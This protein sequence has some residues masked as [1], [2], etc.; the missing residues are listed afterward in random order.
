MEFPFF[1]GRLLLAGVFVAAGVSKLADRNGWRQ[2]LTEFGVPASLAAPLGVSLPVL[3]I[4]V[5]IILIPTATSWWG[6]LGALV[7]LLLF[8]AGIGANL[9]QGRKPVC[10]CFGRLDSAPI[11]W[12]TLVR[13]GGLAAIAALV[14]SQDWITPHLPGADPWLVIV[15]TFAGAVIL[16]QGWLL[17]RLY[18]RL[19]ALETRLADTGA[20]PSRKG[21]PIGAR[22]P[23][24]KLAALEGDTITLE[25]LRS[26]GKTI[27]LVFT[28]P[29]CGPC[30]KLLPTL[31]RWQRE[32]VS[33]LT[34]ANISQGSPEANR[35]NA[36]KYGLRNVLTQK[37]VE[38]QQAYRITATPGAVLVRVDGTIGS[39]MAVGEEQIGA[40]IQKTINVPRNVQ[41]FERALRAVRGRLAL[42]WSR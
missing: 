34:I 15:G 31:G 8:S 4:V 23:A 32:H 19:V 41:P 1:V 37:G 26:A 30:Q 35:T 12:H 25:H 3:E 36:D 6:A 39:T 20:L 7:L 13:N 42:S 33:Q 2:A 14:L 18:R 21:L 22:A 38:V 27:L 24:F 28:N 29:S 16:L 10:H 9:A 11:G 17:Y 5:A 40:L